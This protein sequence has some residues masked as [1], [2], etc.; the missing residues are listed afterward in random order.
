[1]RFD[2]DVQMEE[3]TTAVVLVG[4]VKLLVNQFFCIATV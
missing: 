4:R 1:M 3:D 2:G